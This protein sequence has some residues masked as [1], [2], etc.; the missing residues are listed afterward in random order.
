MRNNS[1]FRLYMQSDLS[2]SDFKVLSLLYQ[3]LLGMESYALYTT[4]YQMI[5]QTK[6]ESLTH[7]VLFDLLDLKQTNFLKMRHKLEALNLLETYQ[8]ENEFIYLLKTP[9]TAKQFLADT[10][11]GSYLQSEIGDKNLNVLIEMFKK[12]IPNTEGYQ[13]ISKPF[14]ALYEFKQLNL[15]KVDDQLEGRMQNQGLLIESQF[16]FNG[17]V[18]A[19]PDRLKT[20]TLL[21]RK[22][23]E[24]IEKIAFVYQYDVLD[25]VEVYKKASE[26]K[27]NMNYQ[28]LNFK[29]RQYFEKKN[30]VLSIKEK[31]NS[32]VDLIEKATPYEII[33]KFAKVDQQGIA[34]STAFQLLERNQVDPGIVNVILMLVL[35]HKD[36]ILP[37][38]NYLE[39]VLNDWLNK[40]VLTT[41]DAIEHASKLEGSFEQK[42]EKKVNKTAE[43]D[44]MDDYVRKIAEMEE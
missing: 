17:F 33:S 13:N 16:D 31:T 43:P 14:D 6:I 28:V 36:G 40:G 11:F 3:P 5:H 25:M 44:W 27:Q 32:E 4:F 29:A 1:N 9:L 7:Q 15:L 23:R 24:T 8:L 35:K 2:T 22:L 26:S 21:N 34:L 30:Q 20:S 41:E 19:L 39:K 10:V 42:K 37:H 38:I 12:E 18:E